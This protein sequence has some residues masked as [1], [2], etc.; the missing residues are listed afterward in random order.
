MNNII[1]RIYTVI[2]YTRAFGVRC[3][4]IALFKITR[5][6][7]TGSLNIRG[8]KAPVKLRPRGS[9][10][11]TAFYKV[12]M[13]REYDIQLPFTPQYIID[14]GANIGLVSV[15]F[16][17]RYPEA[18]IIAIEPEESNFEV[19]LENIKPYPQI[20]GLNMALWHH[21]SWV[22]IRDGAPGTMSFTV[23]ECG[24]DTPGAIP[25][26]SLKEVMSQHGFDRIDLLKMDIEGSEKNILLHDYDDWL[27]RTNAFIIEL[28]D[29]LQA[30]C[31]SAWLNAVI[32]YPFRIA[33][34]TDNLL[35][36]K[37]TLCQE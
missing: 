10:D 6:K 19:L 16:A 8:L 11:K 2:R 22:R 34:K 12:I 18:K 20:T 33:P 26:T 14:A 28:H 23:E 31:S 35:L 25:A 17:N 13:N 5:T 3:G 4:L 7:R 29:D 37:D 32:N 27:S 24:K 36:I 21:P 15:F 30:G 1:E 9:S